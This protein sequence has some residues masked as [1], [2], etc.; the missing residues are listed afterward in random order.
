MSQNKS[1]MPFKWNT[2]WTPTTGGFNVRKTDSIEPWFVPDRELSAI[3]V[4]L[5][6]AIRI[7]AKNKPYIG[8]EGI[9]RMLKLWDVP[10]HIQADDGVLVGVQDIHEI[11][12]DDTSV[13]MYGD[14]IFYS[15]QALPS[16]GNLVAIPLG[17]DTAHAVAERV[18][19]DDKY[20]R[21]LERH[22]I[23]VAV[24]LSPFE[25]LKHMVSDEKPTRTVAP[26]DDLSFVPG[27]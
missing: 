5:P 14:V 24:G 10:L 4:R 23:S 6:E 15:M 12:I 22:A 13:G 11:D 16:N 27:I 9:T 19:L 18:W 20:P 3:D 17:I 1:E 21:W 26:P 7:L 8:G 2:A 25:V